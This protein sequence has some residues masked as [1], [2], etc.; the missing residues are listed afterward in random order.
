MTKKTCPNCGSEFVS[1]HG[2]QK[3]CSQ[4]ECSRDRNIKK[5]RKWNASEQGR[6]S[7]RKY[8]RSEK[9]RLARSRY[10][11]RNPDRYA[12][13]V[14]KYINAVAEKLDADL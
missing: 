13:K 11:V 4:T 3:F 12:E 7:A 2:N 1:G 9:G 6:Q 10:V 14:I 5:L 8:Q